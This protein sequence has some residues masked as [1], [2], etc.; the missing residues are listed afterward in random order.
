MKFFTLFEMEE[1]TEGE[2]PNNKY[3]I[4]KSKFYIYF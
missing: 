4:S 3:F 2:E 1:W